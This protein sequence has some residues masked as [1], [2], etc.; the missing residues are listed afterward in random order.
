M[1]WL[2]L[3]DDG[4]NRKAHYS[5]DGQVFRLLHSVGRT[6]YLTADEIGFCWEGNHASATFNGRLLSWKEA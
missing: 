1:L 3:E 2:R 6:D 4:T 5:I